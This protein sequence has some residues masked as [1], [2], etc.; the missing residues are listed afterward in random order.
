[1]RR[2]LGRTWFAVAALAGMLATGTADAEHIARGQCETGIPADEALGLVWFP[3]GDLFCPLIADPKGAGSFASYVRGTSTSA[4]GTDIA[5]VGIGDE[6]GLFRV[7]GPTIGDGVQLSLAGN[8]YAQFDLNAPSYD[9][10]NA[11]YLLGLPLVIRRGPIA[12]R[13]R[14]YHQSSHLGDEFILRGPVV[15][16]NLAF[17]SI[18]GMLSGEFG[19]LRLYGGGEYLF[20]ATPA[21]IQTRL[22]HGGV[23]LRQPGGL[24]PI[25]GFDRARLVA[26]LDVKAVEDLAWA[27]AWSGR[28][29]IELGGRP[30]AGHASRRLSL[31]GEYYDGPSPYGQFFRDNV[32]YYGFG[33]HIGL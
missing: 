19:P 28:A 1:M 8:V 18:E 9:L 7:N 12:T 29:G 2:P 3:R 10:I 17:Q 31:L 6:L 21:E 5:S 4:F 33:L 14:L 16:E 25:A 26:G 15:R 22:V 11:D 27:V 13:I 20:G 32:T 23:E 24:L 30:G